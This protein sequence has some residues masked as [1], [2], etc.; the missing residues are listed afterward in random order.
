MDSS[1]FG[2][3]SSLQ[4]KE[5]YALYYSPENKFLPYFSDDIYEAIL[6]KP[7]N[8]VVKRYNYDRLSDELVAEYKKSSLYLE[9]GTQP[10]HEQHISGFTES[11]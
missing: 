5:N 9:Q 6:K 2:S 3:C 11:F 10:V 4:P 8:F 7:E 1:K